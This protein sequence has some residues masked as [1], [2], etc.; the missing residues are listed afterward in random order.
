M[1]PDG[2][3][4]SLH[5]VVRRFKIVM[6]PFGRV[7]QIF[8]LDGRHFESGYCFF[9]A[10]VSG[11]ELMVGKGKR[12]QKGEEEKGTRGPHYQTSILSLIV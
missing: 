10:S 12:R 6:S 5:F 11:F 9:V 2:F 3:V 1:L 7:S 8:D 4:E